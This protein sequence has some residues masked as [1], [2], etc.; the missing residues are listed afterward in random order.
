MEISSR[1]HGKTNPLTAAA[2]EQH[3]L[4]L[5]ALGQYDES[6]EHLLDSLDFYR[7]SAPESSQIPEIAGHL[8]E[9][10]RAWGKEEKMGEFAALA[11][12]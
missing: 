7:L 10:Y 8:V 3:G 6:E 11:G 1:I 2:R 4:A 12:S 9:L 5:I